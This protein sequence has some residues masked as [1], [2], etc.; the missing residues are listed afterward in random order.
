MNLVTLGAVHTHTHTHTHTSI[1]I[2][3]NNQG[4]EVALFVV[5]ENNNNEYINNK[6]LKNRVL[7]KNLCF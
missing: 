7:K 3:N 4:L 2:L 6:C 1:S 5:S